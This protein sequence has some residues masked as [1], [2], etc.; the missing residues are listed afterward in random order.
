MKTKK[1][2]FKE[3]ITWYTGTEFENLTMNILKDMF[4]AVDEIKFKD[5]LHFAWWVYDKRLQYITVNQVE[6]PQDWELEVIVDNMSIIFVAVN[7]IIE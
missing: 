2:Y 1:M 3:F 6:T 7:P 5:D 4:D